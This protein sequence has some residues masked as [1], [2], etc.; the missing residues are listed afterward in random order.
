MF[1]WLKESILMDLHDADVWWVAAQNGTCMY[2]SGYLTIGWFVN[3]IHEVL[4]AT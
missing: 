4:G 2:W 3:S 1:Q